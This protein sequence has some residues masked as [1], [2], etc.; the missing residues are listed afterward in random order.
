MVTNWSAYYHQQVSYVYRDSGYSSFLQGK[1]LA[2]VIKM[3]HFS[4]K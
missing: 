2:L 1:L 3:Q 4:T